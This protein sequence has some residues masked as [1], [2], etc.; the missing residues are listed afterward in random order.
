MGSGSILTA[1]SITTTSTFHENFSAEHVGEGHLVQLVDSVKCSNICISKWLFWTPTTTTTCIK[2][3]QKVFN[4]EA[5]VQ[6]HF[7]HWF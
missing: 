6:L 7:W 3:Q 4:N 5:A 1:Q 2:P